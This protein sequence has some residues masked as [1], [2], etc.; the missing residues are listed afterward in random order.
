[1]DIR[2]V[3]DGQNLLRHGDGTIK[4]VNLELARSWAKENSVELIVV[5]PKNRKYEKIIQ[6]ASDVCFVN[7][8]VYDDSAIIQIAIKQK[9]PILSNDKFRDFKEI[10]PEYDF[11]NQVFPFDIIFDFIITQLTEYCRTINT[12]QIKVV[13]ARSDV[14]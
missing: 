14:A 10:Y 12:N 11:D 9:L 2:I 6:S 7:S 3:V 13:E 5:L 4:T 1:M 8:N